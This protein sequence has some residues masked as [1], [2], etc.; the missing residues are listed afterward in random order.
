MTLN[1]IVNAIHTPMVAKRDTIDEAFEYALM[2]A[3]GT[4][5]PMAVM[6]AVYVVT[7]TIANMLKEVEQ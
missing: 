6:T 4:D 2:V 7:N 1:E 5:T 3:K